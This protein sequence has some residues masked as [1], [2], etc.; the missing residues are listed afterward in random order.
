[1]GRPKRNSWPPA[2]VL[3]SVESR[4]TSKVVAAFLE[5]AKGGDTKAADALLRRTLEF[6]IAS[7]LADRLAALEEVA[8]N[9]VE[10][11]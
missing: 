5:Q 8:S 2:A 4:D 10:I 7:D 9:P 1:M 3:R 11:E 6:A